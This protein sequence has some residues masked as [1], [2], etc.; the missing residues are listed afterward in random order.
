M[1]KKELLMELIRFVVIGV[2]GTLID[3]AVEGWLTSFASK[4]CDGKGAVV[5]FFIMFGVSLIGW[6]VATPATWALTSIWGFRNV[7]EDDE[8]KAKSLRGLVNFTLLALAV[9]V[10]GA[11]IQF[12]GYMVC[13]NSFEVNIVVDF[14]FGE[15]ANTGN[16]KALIAWGSVFVIRTIVT[17]VLNYVTRK[18]ILYRA[19]K[20]EKKEEASTE[21]NKE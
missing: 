15:I 4:W 18:F 7:R 21:E 2:Y 14:N 5:A 1:K 8:K 19:P 12:I 6:L 11:I 10:V 9:L 13:L 17:M 3:M 16:Y 20:E